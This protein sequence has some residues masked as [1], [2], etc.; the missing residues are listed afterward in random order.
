LVNV[1]PNYQTDCKPDGWV[2]CYI[3]FNRRGAAAFIALSTVLGFLS[4][5]IATVAAAITLIGAGFTLAYKKS[6]PFRKAI[7]G[8]GSSFKAMFKIFN[9]G[10]K[11]YGGARNILEKAGLSD[12]QIKLVISFAYSLKGAFD[13]IKSVFSGVFHIFKGEHKAAIDVLESAGYQKSSLI[14]FVNLDTV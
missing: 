10:F 12:E 2:R 7:N 9:E 14:A 8:I 6:E 4:G 11:G 13:K 1:R 5:T 3:R